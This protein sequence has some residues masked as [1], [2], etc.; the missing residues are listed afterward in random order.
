VA[1]GCASLALLDWR[2]GAAI[3]DN[4]IMKNGLYYDKPFRRRKNFRRRRHPR[5]RVL[6]SRALRFIFAATIGLQGRFTMATLRAFSHAEMDAIL[7]KVP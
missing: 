5:G 6:L 4:L 3:Y 2:E 1:D 7:S